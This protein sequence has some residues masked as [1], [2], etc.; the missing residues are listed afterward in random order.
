MH[1]P[2]LP[3]APPAAPS[4]SSSPP[5]LPQQAKEP[6]PPAGP[7]HELSVPA[8]SGYGLGIVV[9]DI[10]GVKALTHT[11]GLIGYCSRLTFIPSLRIGVCVLTNQ[12]T[13]SVFDAVTWGVLS[14]L[15]PI[16]PFYVDWIAGYAEHVSRRRLEFAVKEEVALSVG[17]GPNDSTVIAFPLPLS[18]LL[19]VYEDVWYGEVEVH[20]KSGPCHRTDGDVAGA[21]ENADCGEIYIRFRPCPGLDG[22]LEHFQLMTWIVRWRDRSL[23]ADAFISFAVDDTKTPPAI[24][25]ATMKAVSP[26]TDFSFDFHHLRLVKK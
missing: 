17:A 2:F 23:N 19:G 13:G 26:S 14:M 4:P 5:P 20:T 9:R 25:H 6:K 7:V 15:T 1:T 3:P 10:G 21:D 8:F 24:T 16:V 22:T 18:S 11:G 12:E